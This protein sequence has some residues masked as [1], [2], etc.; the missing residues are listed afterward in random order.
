[1]CGNLRSDGFGSYRNETVLRAGP[2][3]KQ[4]V[5]V[6]SAVK[7]SSLRLRRRPSG[8]DGASA[9]R[10]HCAC[11][12][13]WCRLKVPRRRLPIVNHCDLWRRVVRSHRKRPVFWWHDIRQRCDRHES[14]P[15]APRVATQTPRHCAAGNPTQALQPPDGGGV[16][17]MDPAIHRVQRYTAPA[18]VERARGH[19]LAY[20]SSPRVVSVLPRRIR[21]A[22]RSCFCTTLSSGSVCPGWPGSCVH[23]APRDCRSC[24]HAKKSLGCSLGFMA[25]CG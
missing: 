14:H 10:A 3:G 22:A 5:A 12:M 16:R 13:P 11:L 23:S 15:S 21:R 18:G 17:R 20:R 6:L 7:G 25:P 19:G 2:S 24:F 9:W 1:M 8:I 4:D